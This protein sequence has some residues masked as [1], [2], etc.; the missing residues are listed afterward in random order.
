MSI[1][2]SS[3]ADRCLLHGQLFLLTIFCLQKR[4]KTEAKEKTE[5]KAGREAPTW[6]YRGDKTESLKWNKKCVPET[7]LKRTVS[8]RGAEV[9]PIRPCGT[10]WV[11]W[12]GGSLLQGSFLRLLLR[13][14]SSSPGSAVTFVLCRQQAHLLPSTVLLLLPLSLI[15]SGC[16][17]P[18]WRRSHHKAVPSASEPSVPRAPPFGLG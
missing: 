7:N 15:L 4:M 11:G 13:T 17:R 18:G 9:T 2:Y 6:N 12:A 3:E 5:G 16:C 1:F 10:F 8:V 14:L